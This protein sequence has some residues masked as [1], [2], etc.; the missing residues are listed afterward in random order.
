MIPSHPCP[1]V[2]TRGLF[3]ERR[4]RKREQATESFSIADGSAKM[5]IVAANS[6]RSDPRSAG[7]LDMLKSSLYS[8]VRITYYGFPREE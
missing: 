6:G 8:V 1:S 7:P 5:L 3:E 2:F 4:D